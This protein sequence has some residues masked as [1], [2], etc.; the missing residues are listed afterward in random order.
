MPRS[1]EHDGAGQAEQGDEGRGSHEEC[2]Q[3][4]VD[5]RRGARDPA[6][7]RGAEPPGEKGEHDSAGRD[8]GSDAEEEPSATGV[9]AEP[10]DEVALERHHGD[11]EGGAHDR[12]REQ[13]LSDEPRWLP[14]RGHPEQQ[15]EAAHEHARRDRGDDRAQRVPAEVAIADVDLGALNESVPD[16][17]PDEEDGERE[18]E[19]NQPGDEREIVGDRESDGDEHEPQD[20]VDRDHRGD[21]PPPRDPEERAAEHGDEYIGGRADRERGDERP[22]GGGEHGMLPEGR[23]AG[24]EGEHDDSRDRSEVPRSARPCALPGF[25]GPRRARDLLLDAGKTADDQI[26]PGP[27]HGELDVGRRADSAVDEQGDRVAG[28]A[29]EDRR[30]DDER[31]TTLP[32][33]GRHGCA[34]IQ[35]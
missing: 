31:E 34:A 24:D 25:D 27:E 33:R 17:R 26:E 23:A 9:I 20:T 35:S 2:D 28:E 29:G 13:E 5:R 3:T 22:S 21:G 19:R 16:D 30:T 15:R 14:D 7:H 18:R 6:E 10:Y 12:D 8:E 4:A 32:S 1:R 11:D